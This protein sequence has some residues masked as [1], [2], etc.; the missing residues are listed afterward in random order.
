[1]NFSQQQSI[2]FNRLNRVYVK[3]LRFVSSSFYEFGAKISNFSET[4]QL[5]VLQKSL[6]SSLKEGTDSEIS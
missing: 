3:N 1:M 5:G 4:L 2:L 6:D